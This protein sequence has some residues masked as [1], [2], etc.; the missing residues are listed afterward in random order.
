MMLEA[1]HILAP[2]VPTPCEVVHRMLDL[3]E[4]TAEDVVY[5]LGCGDGR[6]VI[7]AAKRYGARGVGL[8][9]EPY[10]IEQAQRNARTAGVEALVRFEHADAMAVDLGPATV[11]TLYLVH[12]SMQLVG[13]MLAGRARVGTQVVSHNFEVEGWTPGRTASVTDGDGN[14]HRVYRWTL[15]E[16]QKTGLRSSGA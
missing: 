4:L 9:I 8:D 10:W 16:L 12:W 14:S 7:E 6:I 1:R 15:G 5:D 3:A 13:A 2:Y 11:V